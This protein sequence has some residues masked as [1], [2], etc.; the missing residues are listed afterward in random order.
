MLAIPEEPG[1]GLAINTDAVAE[2]SRAKD[3]GEFLRG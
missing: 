2:F 3:V 1:L